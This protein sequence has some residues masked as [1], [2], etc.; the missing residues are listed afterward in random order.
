MNLLEIG[1]GLCLIGSVCMF[2]G[3][4]FLFERTLISLGNLSFLVG[5]TFLLGPQK[6]FRFFLRRDKKVAS[7]CFFAGFLLVLFGWA[8]VGTLIELYGFW[9]LFSG[10]LPSVVQSLKFIPGMNV[11]LNLPGIRNIVNYAYDQR[12]LPL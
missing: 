2:L 5:L 10:F 8:F 6:T 4:S 9:K 11:V 1:V 3:I 12:R 7:A